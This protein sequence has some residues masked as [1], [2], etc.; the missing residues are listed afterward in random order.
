MGSGSERARQLTKQRLE[1]DLGV[2][3][4]HDAVDGAGADFGR[5]GED[6][7]DDRLKALDLLGEPTDFAL[8]SGGGTVL[9]PSAQLLP[10]EAESLLLFAIDLIDAVEGG[11]VDTGGRIR[12][13]GRIFRCAA[14]SSTPP[15][16]RLATRGSW[17]MGCQLACS[18]GGIAYPL[19]Q[20]GWAVM[21]A[22]APARHRRGAGATE[23]SCR[24][25]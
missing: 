2:A 12:A 4:F 3:H 18:D 19:R 21:P 22:R 1:A 15:S 23:S 11:I 9:P 14:A 10:A 8:L 7:C 20:E 16:I 6:L 24:W 5:Q 25:R 13:W 17:L